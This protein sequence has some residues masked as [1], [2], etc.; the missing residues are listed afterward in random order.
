MF[1]H[2]LSSK[3]L[4]INFSVNPSHTTPW[5]LSFLKHPDFSKLKLC[6]CWPHPSMLLLLTSAF[7]PVCP[8]LTHRDFRPPCLT[9]TFYSGTKTL[10][11]PH[12]PLSAAPYPVAHCS[13]PASPG[14]MELAAFLAS[15]TRLLCLPEEQQT[16]MEILASSLRQDL[17][18]APHWSA[19]CSP[20]RLLQTFSSTL[21]PQLSLALGAANFPPHSQ[22]RQEP[23]GENAL[24][25]LPPA[26]TL[27]QHPYLPS[28]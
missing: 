8:S 6:T 19:L 14:W 12:A 5:S 7:L 4:P 27:Q 23:G 3:G 10:W 28:F 15:S 21:K 18:T 26:F 2:F 25:F 16:T 11:P 20:L 24:K 13:H 22:R 9:S 1:I 17:S